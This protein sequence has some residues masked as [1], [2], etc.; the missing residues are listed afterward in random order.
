MANKESNIKQLVQEKYMQQCKYYKG[1]EE[2]PHKGDKALLWEYE[3]AWVD[4]STSKEGKSLLMEYVGEFN[5][6]G[7]GQ[8][9]VNDGVPINLKALLYN[10]FIHWQ[11]GYGTSIDNASFKEW[12]TSYKKG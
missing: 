8:Y 7:M 11:G 2:C 5:R 12:Y 3:R 4:M 1:E 9:E 10:R 6:A